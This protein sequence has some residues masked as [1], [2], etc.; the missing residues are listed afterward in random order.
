MNI[1]LTPIF[2][3]IIAL[4]AALITLKLIPWIKSK[5][6]EQQ[7]DN[8]ATAAKVAVYAAEQIF[9]HGN[10]EEKLQYAIEKL[11]DNGFTVDY[12]ALR[13]AVEKAVYELKSEQLLTDSFAKRTEQTEQ[14]EEETA[15]EA[16][17]ETAK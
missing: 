3:A 6:T 5:A 8:L 17:D 16:E 10:N 2:Q 7:Y 1:D 14:P 4:L 13:A 15:Q 12:E 9:S 11:S